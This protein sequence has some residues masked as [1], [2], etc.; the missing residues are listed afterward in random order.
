M[1]ATLTIARRELRS[2]FDSPL[3][4]VV[5]CLSLLMLGVGVFA[6]PGRFWQV[7][8]ATLSSMFEVIPLGLVVLIVP[9]VTM[10]LIAEEK[11]SGTLEMLITLPVRDSDV[12]LGKFLGALGLV[13]VLLLSTML[14]PL[15]M[16]KSVWHLGPLD[17]GPVLA[18]YIGL[19]LF[20]AAAVAVGLLISALTDSQVIAF[21]I[22]FIVLGMLYMLGEIAAL[23]PAMLGTVLRAFSFK[24][25]YSS[26][27]RG[28]IDTRDVVFFLSVT[29][30]ALVFAFRA[31]ESR[32]WA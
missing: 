4:Y 31:L 11:R 22:T 7:D 16:F 20:A 12:I 19:I 29:I 18:G 32:K 30:L 17:G 23:V 24:E 13:L 15:L 3:A 9:V 21:F 8:R 14:Y 25:H 1:T 5:I 27:E 26:F 28:L 6:W 10:R 2:Y